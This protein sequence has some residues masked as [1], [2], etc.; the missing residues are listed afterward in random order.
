MDLHRITPDAF[1]N[2][3]LESSAFLDRSQDFE[4]TVGGYFGDMRPMVRTHFKRVG[5]G[6]LRKSDFEV[7][8][9][10]SDVERLIELFCSAG[11]PQAIELSQAKKLA[12]AVKASG[13]EPLN[14]G[15]MP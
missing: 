11:H 1:E 4:I 3:K 14:S 6:K 12:A 8:S 2:Y 15:A 13:W 5:A 7:I 10:W 9:Y